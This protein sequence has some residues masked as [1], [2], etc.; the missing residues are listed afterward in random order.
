VI[1]E[2]NWAALEWFKCW[3]CGGNN[4]DSTITVECETPNGRACKP[5]QVPV[6]FGCYM[7]IDS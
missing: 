3:L 6:H 1:N 7:D 2:A 5:K 4:P